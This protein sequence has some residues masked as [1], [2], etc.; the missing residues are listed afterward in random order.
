MVLGSRLCDAEI[1]RFSEL[2]YNF[3][4]DVVYKDRDLIRL[5]GYFIPRYNDPSN[6]FKRLSYRAGIRFEQ[7]GLNYKGQDIKEFGINVGIGIPA[8]RVFTN[9]NIGVEYYKRGTKDNG[10]VQ[11]DYISAF[12]SF[13]FND[14][15]FIKSKF[16]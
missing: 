3:S 11:E 14:K 15:W 13:S 2:T 6:V 16:N 1:K 9:A 12:L 5:G 7:T 4:E 10:L 8:G